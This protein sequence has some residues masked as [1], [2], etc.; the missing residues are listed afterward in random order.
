MI[1]VPSQS[2]QCSSFTLT[3]KALIGKVF[4]LRDIA[5]KISLGFWKVT[6]LRSGP[7][8]LSPHPH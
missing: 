2:H 8:L 1:Q 3:G 4:L 6:A 5:H 7:C